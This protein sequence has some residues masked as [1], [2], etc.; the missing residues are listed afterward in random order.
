MTESQHAFPMVSETIKTVPDPS[1]LT[2]EQLLREI[3]RVVAL[4]EAEMH[5][6]REVSEAERR[7]IR[8]HVKD[9]LDAIRGKHEVRFI[10]ID[11]RFDAI[12]AVRREQKADTQKNVEDA[13]LA[14]K[15]ALREQ[16]STYDAS[17][18]KTEASIKEQSGQRDATVNARILAMEGV[19]NDVK[20]RVDRMEAA[21]IGSAENHTNARLDLGSVV[22]FIGMLIAIS[23]VVIVLTR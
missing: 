23:T 20:T 14:A 21:K 19:L 2:T 18:T 3:S 8:E 16:K 9:Q 17:L 12:E 15:E 22:G 5:G 7:G 11:D 1:L 4:L 10:G 6:D 13:L